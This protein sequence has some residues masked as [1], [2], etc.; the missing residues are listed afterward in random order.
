MKSIPQ[1]T[2]ASSS[3]SVDCRLSQVLVSGIHYHGVSPR[4]GGAAT[5]DD[6][7]HAYSE[8]FLGKMRCS[9][10]RRQKY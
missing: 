5:S 10:I 8:L 4:G 3:S 6:E 1:P 7:D 9:S 2:V